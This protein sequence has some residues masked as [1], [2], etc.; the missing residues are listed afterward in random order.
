MHRNAD[1]NAAANPTANA[2]RSADDQAK[3]G[4]MLAETCSDHPDMM[5]GDAMKMDN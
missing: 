2:G 1:T 3:S 5:L 4:E